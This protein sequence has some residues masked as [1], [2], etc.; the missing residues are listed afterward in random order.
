MVPCLF[1]S[2]YCG[3]DRLQQFVNDT[4][5]GQGESDG[6]RV[7]I[8]VEWICEHLT[9]MPGISTATT[10]AFDTFL[11]RRGVCRDY[12]HLLIAFARAAGIPARAV[13]VYAPGLDPQDFH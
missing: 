3:S 2:R 5:V 13:S 11:A 12:T 6:D 7:E 8:M 1:P 10:T 9:Y 4:F